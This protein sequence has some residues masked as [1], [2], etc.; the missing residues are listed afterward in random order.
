MADPLS[1]DCPDCTVPPG[2]RCAFSNPLLA[3]TD[4]APR[5]HAERH[6]VADLRAVEHGTCALCGQAMVRGSVEGRPVDAWHPDPDH[7]RACPVIPEPGTDPAGWSLAINLG[8]TPGHPGAEHFVPA[9]P[10]PCGHVPMQAGCG[11][12][13]PSAVDLVIEDGTGTLRPYDPARDLVVPGHILVGLDDGRTPSPQV[14]NRQAALTGVLHPD[15]AV[16]YFPG[17]PG[18]VKET[19]DAHREA[20]TLPRRRWDAEHADPVVCPDCTAGKHPNCDGTAWDHVTDAPTA[21]TCT[22]GDHP[23]RTP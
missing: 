21:C 1:V 12:C 7:A 15:A 23:R 10:P 6:R 8:L 16:P 11:G 20:V 14:E 17:R 19:V 4:D 3:G 13:D 2:T 18:T 9:E 5:Y 22:D